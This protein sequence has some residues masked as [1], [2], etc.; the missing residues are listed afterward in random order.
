MLH[1]TILKSHP[2]KELS[3]YALLGA[4]EI[5]SFYPALYVKP[6]N[7]RAHGQVLVNKRPPFICHFALAAGV[8]RKAR[9]T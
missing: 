3:T 1:W 5:E 2:N 6:T 8:L 9:A 7:P 4:L